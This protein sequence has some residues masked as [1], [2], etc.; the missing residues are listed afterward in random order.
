MT[1]RSN[2]DARP[3][4]RDEHPDQPELFDRLLT[5]AE[6]KALAHEISQRGALVRKE[7]AGY[8]SRLLANERQ[9]AVH[10]KTVRFDNRQAIGQAREAIEAAARELTP[11]ITAQGL[12]VE[13]GRALLARLPTFVRLMI[14]AP[15]SAVPLR[16]LIYAAWQRLLLR[17][18]DP[19]SAVETLAEVVASA[20]SSAP[21]QLRAEAE[22]RFQTSLTNHL[23]AL[24]PLG[25][26]PAA[27]A[28]KEV[29]Q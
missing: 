14:S 7:I 23:A 12:T 8:H 20:I 22:E 13:G 25:C 24:D 11:Q 6:K 2:G 17:T 21:D 18:A 27:I 19:P 3:E 1:G 26:E 15:S 29:L 4:A 10:L 28:T 9:M 16:E 5:T